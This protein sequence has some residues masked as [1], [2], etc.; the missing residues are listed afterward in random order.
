[1]IAVRQRAP[2]QPGHASG[3][4]ML[5][6]MLG[7]ALAD[8]AGIVGAARQPHQIFGQHFLFGLARIHA[9]AGRFREARGLLA[10]AHQHGLAQAHQP[11]RNPRSFARHGIAQVDA[12]VHGRGAQP[13]IALVEIADPQIPAS[14]RSSGSADAGQV[15]RNEIARH[16]QHHVGRAARAL[17][18]PQ[19]RQQALRFAQM[20]EYARPGTCC[21]ATP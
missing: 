18:S 16:Q 20:A 17:E 5:A 15:G 3:R 1:M 12:G 14:L 4:V 10:R 21:G 8:G 13:E 11:D 19:Q 2:V 6:D 9:H 7:G